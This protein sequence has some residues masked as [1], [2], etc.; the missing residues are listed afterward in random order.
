MAQQPFE[1]AA[2]VEGLP[3][4]SSGLARAHSFL[5]D[6][7]GVGGSPSPAGSRLG[8]SNDTLA[9]RPPQPERDSADSAASPMISDVAG[10]PSRFVTL[11]D[12][13]DD[14]KAQGLLTPRKKKSRFKSRPGPEAAGGPSTLVEFL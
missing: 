2:E 1:S 4:S 12:V 13:S 9:R 5:V 3:A 8:S 10:S 14:L 7:I 6:G 11:F